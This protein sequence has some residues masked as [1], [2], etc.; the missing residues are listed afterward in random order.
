MT[1]VVDGTH[2]VGG[3][4]LLA[5]CAQLAKQGEC[6]NSAKRYA[7]ARERSEH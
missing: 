7:S 1:V 6:S 2:A 3:Y 5:N 4:D